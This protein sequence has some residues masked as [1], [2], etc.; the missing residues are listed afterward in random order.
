MYVCVCFLR[1]LFTQ[2]SL[3]KRYL[4]YIKYLV[5]KR[6][7]AWIMHLLRFGDADL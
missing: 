4:Y 7:S 2:N 6:S 3:R 1:K 5:H